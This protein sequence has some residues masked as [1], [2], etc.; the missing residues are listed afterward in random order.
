MEVE[1]KAKKKKQEAKKSWEMKKK[2]VE[3]KLKVVEEDIKAQNDMMT[4]ALSRGGRMKDPRVKDSCIGT[5]QA[6][7][8]TIQGKM[9]E[10]KVL[11][12]TLSKLM[13]KKPKK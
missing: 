3:D 4:A 5:V 2:D 13:S 1:Q 10:Q 9:E 8:E 11:M 7:Q 6:C 12:N